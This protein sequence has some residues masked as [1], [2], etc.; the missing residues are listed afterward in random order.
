MSNNSR[1]SCDLS[2][3]C[4][5]SSVEGETSD[6]S[7]VEG[8]LQTI[9]PYRFEPEANDWPP[10]LDTEAEYDNSRDEERLHCRDW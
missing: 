3:I 4:S 6:I 10:D 2:L 7:E 8:D 9:K 5:V 1:D